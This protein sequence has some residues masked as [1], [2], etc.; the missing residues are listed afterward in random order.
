VKSAR[1]LKPVLNSAQIHFV[2][3][4]STGGDG[5]VAS[6]ISFAHLKDGAICS[7]IPL[8][9]KAVSL[10]NGTIKQPIGRYTQAV[11]ERGRLL[12]HR[13]ALSLPVY[14]RC[15]T[16]AAYTIQRIGR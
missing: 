7:R 3:L 14:S 8:T 2:I 15:L 10:G 12:K 9:A 1:A 5:T 4:L 13:R 16:G 11:Y 6:A